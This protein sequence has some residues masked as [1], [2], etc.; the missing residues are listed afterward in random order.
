MAGP[1]Y[2]FGERAARGLEE[3]T[4]LSAAAWKGQGPQG[5]EAPS[6]ALEAAPEATLEA[7]DVQAGREPGQ[8]AQLE[9]TCS[10]AGQGGPGGG[11]LQWSHEVG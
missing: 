5:V 8:G 7:K 6:Q 3:G 2:G 4:L 11:D 10:L 1:G 9:C